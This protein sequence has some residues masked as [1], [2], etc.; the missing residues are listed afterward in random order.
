MLSRN[1]K[2]FKYDNKKTELLKLVPKYTALGLVDIGMIIATFETVKNVNI[3]NEP[4]LPITLTLGLSMYNSAICI[5]GEYDYKN[6]L[7]TK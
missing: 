3:Y 5:L 1:L 4:L 7:K 2:V 6:K